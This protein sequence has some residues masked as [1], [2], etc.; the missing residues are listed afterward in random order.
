VHLVCQQLQHFNKSVVVFKMTQV[1]V[2]GRLT[3]W[4]NLGRGLVQR[5]RHVV[6]A[7]KMENGN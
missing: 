4:H 2:F 5:Y 7:S 3:V 6:G 1:Q